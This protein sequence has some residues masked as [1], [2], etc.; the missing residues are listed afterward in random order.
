MTR[1]KKNRTLGLLTKFTF[2]DLCKCR[3]VVNHQQ[4]I[5][6]TIIRG[7]EFRGGSR[8][9]AASKMELFVT[10]FNCFWSLTIATKSS[11]LDAVVAL[12]PT[13]RVHVV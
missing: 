4:P 5:K 12:D 11:I 7:L 1:K 8:T 2:F 6:F 3:S 13:L 9:N 10:I